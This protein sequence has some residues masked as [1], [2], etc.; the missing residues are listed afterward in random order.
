[1][2]RAI[3]ASILLSLL[4]CLVM[5]AQDTG[6][7][8][9]TVADE[10]GAVIPN[11]TVT[12]TNKTAGFS[13][14]ATTNAEGYFSAV[15]IPAGNY[16]V[17]AEVAGFRT[18][19]R[20]ATVD[21]GGSTQ[22]NM[23]MS[24]GQTQEVVTVEAATAQ[25][26]YETHNITGVIQRNE[27]QDIPLNGRSYLQ[28]AALQPGVTIASGT[29]A[30]FNVLFT[31][32]V[33]GAGNRTAV[34]IDGGNVSD[35]I[36]VAG[37]M[38]SMNFSQETV[39]EFQLS[40]VNFDIATPIAA[41]GAINVVTRSGSN[42]WHGSGYFFF[43][44]HN[45]AAYPNLKRL[46]GLADPFFARRNP[47]F[48]IGGP[49][50][51]DKLFFF[52]NY[53]YMN[54]V[55]ALSIQ[56]TGPAFFPLQST[57]GSPY[58]GK[59]TSLRLDYHINSKHTFF[60]RYS[61][62]GNSGFGQSL[63]FGDP[64]NWP[65]NVNW[66]D[67]SII[68]L[69]SSLTP[70]IVNDIRVQYNYWNNHNLP[71][72]AS[73]CSAP[74]VAG[75][76]PNPAGGTVPMPNVFTFFGS[77]MP[78]V[79]PNFNAPQGRNTRRF[80]LVESLSWQKGSHRFK[81]GGDLNPT[82]SAGLWGFCTPLCVGAFSPDYVRAAVLPAVGAAT[83]NAL[84]P[85]LPTTL[86]TDADVLNLP[87]LNINSSIFSGIGVGKVS[88]PAAYDY[89][90]NKHYDQW[91]MYFQDVWKIRPNF[92]FNYGLAWNAQAGFYNSD[93]PKPALLSPIL[94]TGPDVLGATVNNLKEFQPA[95]G[96]AWSPF[97]DNKTVIRG[98][99]GIY[100]DSTP[101]YYKLREASVIGPPGSARSTLSASAFTNLYP[102]IINFN[103]GAPIPVGAAL[104]LSALT[105]MTIGQFM[106]LVNQELPAVAAI[107]APD[108]PV[109]SGA[110]PY[111][112]LNFAKQ[113]VEIYPTHF[114]LARSYQTSIGIQRDLGYG[115]VL[116]ADWARRQGE[117]V[118]LGE[119]DQNLFARYLG[120]PTPVPVIPLC[121]KIPDFDPTHACSTGSVTFW[122]DQGRS[123]YNGLLMRLNKRFSHRYQFQVSYAYAKALGE[124]VWDDTNYMAG[125]GEY[126][127]HHNLGISGTVNMPWGF[128]LSLNSSMIS[129][130]PVTPTV[131]SLIMPGTVAA[132]SSEPLPGLGY[133][134]LAAGC[135]Q[136]DLATAVANFNNNIV[137]TKNAQGAAIGPK[138]TLPQSY[139][140]GEP[141]IT[142]DIRLTKT[143]TVKER[144]KINI[145][146]EMFNVFN[147][148]NLSGF[149]FQLDP[150]TT[151]AP[152]FGQPTQRINQTFGSA[153]PRAV[154]VGARITF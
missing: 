23:P 54:Q 120:S 132:G 89:D 114:P 123:V 1:M 106:N 37:G 115:M 102:G 38:S 79:G 62:D 86:K 6:T 65:H 5:F 108:N 72:N 40:E 145:L 127:P 116:T 63:E 18:L 148:A 139:E 68:G 46:P 101:G 83:F 70:T 12:I 113:G 44:D 76:V 151:T 60:L 36:D 142:Q 11:V 13:R 98:G 9:G 93:L 50:K 96:F 135:G 33:L 94:G 32:S 56:T 35:N 19:V 110:F 30:Q 153:G 140:F 131:G 134:C 43:R 150:V 129:R 21:A 88:L 15:A 27:I 119:V 24:L 90:Q 16:E 25:I 149:S 8:T 71:S 7:I 75:I 138:L 17:K 111:P 130:T 122:T 2:S 3:A 45:M 147:I 152:A 77:N 22:V 73:D 80:E 136:S 107:L 82:K 67:Q 26:N 112:N 87:V 49:I 69:T 47:G 53:E 91:R 128:T 81:F 126:L 124:A 52:F 61:H 125:Y 146:G 103:T 109:R 104:P 105:N 20:P 99:A 143:F 117:N 66:A 48:S 121:A 29:V 10:S 97:K 39:Q 51:K 55:Q 4:C 78:A 64:S 28:L 31:V 41:G 14:T 95:V 154:Q 85:T 42:D 58:I 84:F 59:Q 133:G 144:W 92:T 57:Y 74:C 34:T 137:G 118:S 100:W 141:T